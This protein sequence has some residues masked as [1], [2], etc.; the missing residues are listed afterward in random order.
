MPKVT[1]GNTWWGKQ[2]L[3]ALTDIDDENR[4]PRGV[5]Y[6]RNG[7][8][9]SIAIKGNKV[10]AKVQGSM[11][12]PYTVSITVP[13]FK[14]SAGEAIVEAVASNRLFLARLMTRKLPPELYDVLVKKKVHLFPNKWGDLT[15]E[16]SCPDWAVPCK[17]IAAVVYL[18]ANEI[19]K[20]PFLV[21]DLHDFDIFQA[22][23]RQGFAREKTEN[24]PILSFE[25]I[26][27]ATE[28][29]K[30]FAMDTKSAESVDFSVIPHLKDELLSLLPE[31]ALFYP[32][33][34]FKQLVA[35][36]YREICD[37]AREFAAP[38]PEDSFKRD[39]EEY[40]KLNAVF[41][42][43]GDV[44]RLT[45][46]TE[47]SRF[48]ISAKENFE[49]LV[50]FLRAIAPA[51]LTHHSNAVIALSLWYR[52][53]ARLM[54]Q[55]AFVPQLVE[56][57]NA[58][59]RIRLV[60][61]LLHET[62][63]SVFEQLVR[64]TPPD[65]I[66]FTADIHTEGAK[67][68]T[69][70]ER[71]IYPAP[72]E[73]GLFLVSLFV[74]HVVEQTNAL[75]HEE[76]EN[77]IARLFFKGEDFIADSFETKETPQAI[78]AWLSKFF[79]AH[80]EI[81]PL[82]KIEAEGSRFTLELFGENTKENLAPPIPLRDILHLDSHRD[83][84]ADF[85][86]D[87]A[88]LAEQFPD[89]GKLISSEGAQKLTFDAETFVEVFFKALPSIKLLG[90]RIALPK[91]LRE[92]VSPQLTIS[93]RKKQGAGAA[94]S[95][96][97]MDALLDFDWRVALGDTIVQAEEF[98]RLLKD[99]CGIVR[100]KDRYVYIDEGEAQKL[101][102]VLQK[103][104]SF[105]SRDLFQSALTGEY[106]FAPIELSEEVAALIH[107]LL[108]IRNIP[109]PETVRASLR[110]YQERGYSWL[111]KNARVGFNSLIADDMGLGKTLQVIAA[112]AKLK[113]EGLT[114]A[115]PGIIVV[116]T[117]LLTNWQ[118]EVKKFAPSLQLSIYHGAGRRFKKK[119]YDALLTTYGT[120]RRESALFI[121]TKWSFV[122]VDE[123]QNIKNAETAQTKAIKSLSAPVRIAMTGTPVENRLSEFWSIM[124]FLNKGYLGG[125]Q[126]FF[127]EFAQPIEMYRDHAALSRFRAITAPFILRR[128]KTDKTIISDL[129]DK[130]EINQFC[131]L[132]KVQASLYHA[133]VN[134]IMK[135][136]EESE[137]IERRGLVFKLITG[138]KQI[139]NHPAH[140]LK[141]KSADTESSGKMAL[142]MDILRTIYDNDEK[143]LLF[144][145]YAEMG[146]LL[147]G[148]LEREFKSETLFLHGGTT[149]K[150][151]DIIV[152][153]F[154]NERQLNTLILSL[155]AGGTG[156]NLTAAGNVIHF[157]LW[158][159]PA[160]EAQATDRAHRIGQ[161][162]RVMVH[163]FIT[164]DTFEEKINQMLQDKKELADLAVAKGEKWVG[165]L[166][167]K[168]LQS[169][170]ALSSSAL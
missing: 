139:C 90:I 21:F 27:R 71:L 82:L 19:D 33:G 149:R 119:G 56:M 46:E 11:P 31:E 22:L 95:Y 70:T 30:S 126:T 93:M 52:F 20:N 169:L 99:A 29:G 35:R 39:T 84:R 105:S 81:T 7:S 34:K 77:P 40:V 60:P 156:L 67:K 137:G 88:L 133:L 36:L 136:I 154:Q 145:Q 44:K 83:H 101:L 123:A 166:S 131:A 155:K 134:T 161:T 32:G 6:A 63:K 89:L 12:R 158:W 164:K 107:S 28:T 163:R 17:H 162:K 118:R 117:T 5:S 86:R 68:R 157:D 100:F 37:V 160:V 112:I 144:T 16:C 148:A 146:H 49:N 72:R 125:A 130:N 170:F 61:A 2:W 51:K 26:I 167:N 116:P 92:L 3:N 91:E 18:I 78:A 129:P 141:K 159:N 140:Y 115:A 102:R 62:M 96:L 74:N 104:P 120:V 73:Q 122:V 87:C 66:S 13:P 128:V 138:L 58:R 4:L 25:S 1:F 85:M 111:Y 147:V 109:L 57:S 50:N 69:R 127:E 54:E 24:A 106:R 153:R 79:I 47:D 94:K 103:P 150:N 9:K 48:V 165:E 152:D 53:A 23:A 142:L 143:I 38:H 121:K 15:A 59:Y 108:E 114:N 98:K 43:N 151:R 135:D 8:V 14:K 45:L 76:R 55:S 75:S 80:K 113:E 10:A 97:S 64:L 110:H 65:M 124:D 41:D 168:E 132:T 42:R